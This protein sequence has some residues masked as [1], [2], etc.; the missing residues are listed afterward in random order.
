M[1][2]KGFSLKIRDVSKTVAHKKTILSNAKIDIKAGEF[3]AIVGCSGAGKTTLINILTEYSKQSKGNIY[4]NDI[5]LDKNEYKFKGKIGYVPQQEMLYQDLTLMQML[6]YSYDLKNYTKDKKEKEMKIDEII[7]ALEL[8]S[9]QNVMIKKLSGG[10]KKRLSMAVE[11]LSNPD[12]FFLDEPTS[13][14]DSHIEKKFMQLL[15]K[16]S[17]SGITVI[18][19]AHTVLNLYLCDKILFIGKEG[20]ICYYGS[21][22]NSFNYFNV[23][24]FVDIYDILNKDTESWYQ[25]FISEYK[26]KKVK[27]KDY[28]LKVTSVPFLRQLIT[29]IKRN[30]RVI[31]NNKFFLILLLFQSLA[32]G[33]LVCVVVPQNTFEFYDKAKILLFALTCGAMWLG[34]FNSIQEICKEKN[35]L[36]KE[37]MENVSFVAYIFAKIIVLGLICAFQSLLLVTLIFNFVDFPSTGI[38]IN[39]SYM[40]YVVNFFLIEFSSCTTGM[41]ISALVSKAET[42]LIIAPIYMMLQLLF[43]GVLFPLEGISKDMSNFMVGKWSQELFGVSSNMINVA[44]NSKIN[45]DKNEMQEN[46]KKELNNGMIP[47]IDKIANNISNSS[48]ST[49]KDSIYITEA[50]EYYEY[51]KDHAYKCIL[52][53]CTISIVCITGSIIVLRVSIRRK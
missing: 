32:I 30:F 25:K 38:L 18:I 23:E 15:K 43:A 4:I 17:S 31:F 21:Y 33:G 40:E 34:L 10:E 51:T 49:V 45:I 19:T 36:K 22:E 7:T 14:L 41:L 37:Y 46:I 29:L 26:P 16:L 44:E 12:I 28:D 3:I 39:N 24:Q 5:D 42:T 27:V 6:E 8:E 11:L 2:N 13:G 9:C 53:L 50:K 1:K 52:I 47:N 48:I 20:K 35:I